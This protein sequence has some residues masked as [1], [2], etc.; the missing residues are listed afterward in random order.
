[1]TVF[2]NIAYGLSVRPRRIRPRRREIERRANEWLDM[3]Q[4]PELGARYPGQLSGGQRQRVALARAMAIEPR[5]LLLDEPFGALDA[6][7][8]KD[9]RQWLREIHDRTGLTTVFVTHDQNEAMELADRVAIL[10]GGRIEQVGATDEIKRRPASSFVREFISWPSP[11]RGRL[12]SPVRA[13]VAMARGSSPLADVVDA[14]YRGVAMKRLGIVLVATLGLAGLAHAADLPTTKPAPAPKPNCF[15]SFW[16]WL[17]SS[18]D[19]CPVSYAGLTVY[20]AIDV[21]LGYESNGA[22]FNQAYPNA[23]AN[24]ISRQ[25]N[26]PKWLWTPNGLSQSVV[27]IKMSEPIGAG[28]SVVGT[29]EL[30]FNPYSGYLANGQR[31]LVM[32]NGKPLIWQN[33]EGDTSRNG[34]WDNSQGFIGVSNKTYGALTW[35]RVNTLSLDGLIAYDPMGN[36]YAF[37]PFGYSGIYAGF[38]DTEIARSNT[39]VK[40]RLDFMNFRAAGLVQTGGYNVGN[41]STEMYQGQIG[42]DFN[43]FGGNLSLDGIGGFAKD[44]VSPSNFTGSCAFNKLGIFTCTSGIPMFY[45]ADD[46]KATLSNNTG[47]LLMAKY[48]W[49]PVKL[50]GGWEYY[51]QANPSDDYLNGFKTM[52]GY[53]VPGTVP[54]TFP[55]AAKFWPTAWT[56]FTAYNNNRIVNVV[57]GG[58]KYAVN[59]QLDVIGAFYYETQNNYYTQP[60]TGTGIHITNSACAGTRDAFSFMVDYRPV[61]RVDL[62]AG[63]M[64]SNVYGGFANG[65]QQVQDIAPTAGLRVKF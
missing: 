29:L 28:W 51:R 35:G 57:W 10:N 26:G 18:A 59:D 44:G 24:F 21:G 5:V 42:G 30:G 33:A 53:S 13:R 8:R 16:T 60:C 23:V 17:N 47:V 38:G 19:E 7:V 49:G 43:L 40:Y 27:G 11:R 39:A 45:N 22:G 4:P 25:S 56:T 34:Q 58:A 54:S 64:L 55:G 2:D 1:M 41:G 3:V 62:Y 12:S 52:G 15:S 63:V 9:L 50:F 48:T 31:S 61:K 37:S 46:L 32:N 6:K 20:A 36:A 14:R 65:F